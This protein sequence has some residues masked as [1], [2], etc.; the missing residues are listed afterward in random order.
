MTSPSTEKHADLLRRLADGI[1]RLGHFVS[2]TPDERRWRRRTGDDW[3]AHNVLIH[4]RA[5]NEI[6]TPRVM[7]M[8]VRDEPPLPAFDERAW[9]E[10]AGYAEMAP[11]ALFARIAMPR[12]ELIQTLRR[13]G[14]D[15]WTRSGIHEQHG[16]ITVEQLVAHLIDHEDEHLAQIEEL[17]SAP[18]E[19]SDA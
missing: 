18:I 16:R 10:I 13:A 4:L 15:A 9:A 17:L 11:D 1:I 3:S 7:Q 2:E 19:E 6:L 8:L 5:S 14:D 12:Y